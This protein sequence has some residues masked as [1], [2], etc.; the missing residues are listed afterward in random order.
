MLRQHIRVRHAAARVAL[1]RHA[2]V[3]RD[4][5][6]VRVEHGLP[7]ALSVE[8]VDERAG[9]SNALASMAT[10]QTIQPSRGTGMAASAR[11]TCCGKCLRRI[12]RTEE[13]SGLYPIELV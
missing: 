4:D 8:L 7:G 1:Q 11:A 6:E 9:A 10:Y 2:R 5:V 3:A 13:R 12:E